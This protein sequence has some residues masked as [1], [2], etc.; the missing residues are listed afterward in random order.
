MPRETSKL[1]KSD[2]VVHCSVENA[3][4]LCKHHSEGVSELACLKEEEAAED[5]VWQFGDF[6]VR[7]FRDC[8]LQH[9][10]SSWPGIH[11]SMNS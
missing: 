8:F 7:Y 1:S 4:V 10:E 3:A 11:L 2:G 6:L 5:Q 9:W